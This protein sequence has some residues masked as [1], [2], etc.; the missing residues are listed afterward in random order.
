LRACEPRFAK[1][2]LLAFD[3]ERQLGSAWRT[4]HHVEPS[5]VPTAAVSLTGL[6]QSSASCAAAVGL[7]GWRTLRLPQP[8][9]RYRFAGWGP[10]RRQ[11]AR[12]AASAC[13]GSCALGGYARYPMLPVSLREPEHGAQ[14]ARAQEVVMPARYQSSY[15]TSVLM[16]RAAQMRYRPTPSERKLFSAIWGACRA[17]WHV[18]RSWCGREPDS[19]SRAARTGTA[20]APPSGAAQG[21]RP[22]PRSRLSRWLG[23]S[24]A[25]VRQAFAVGAWGDSIP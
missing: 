16:A 2:C 9:L 15:R 25:P 6:G 17:S 19:P 7:L 12:W 22:C 23:S 1:V 20:E 14:L 13:H 3:C 10:R 21:G 4:C 24:T 11:R 18:S 8:M 5:V